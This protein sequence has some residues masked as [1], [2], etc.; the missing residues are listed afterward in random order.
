MDCGVRMVFAT[1]Q[2]ADRRVW[3]ILASVDH[4]HQQCDGG[5]DKDSNVQ[6][7]CQSCNCER[8]L[9]HRTQYRC[10]LDRGSAR[11]R[12]NREQAALHAYGYIAPHHGEAAFPEVAPTQV[13]WFV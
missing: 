5:D 8:Q 9:R 11:L 10:S 3:P 13:G 4:V 7:V 1:Q 12:E 2:N 6:V